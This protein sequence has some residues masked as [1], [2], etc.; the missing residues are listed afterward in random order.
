MSTNV[1]WRPGDSN[2]PYDPLSMGENEIA[3]M[4]QSFERDSND[5]LMV[6]HM[7]NIVHDSAA[8]EEYIDYLEGEMD[9]ADKRGE[10]L[11]E[12]MKREK[13]EWAAI[14]AFSLKLKNR[15]SGSMKA[16]HSC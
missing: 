13:T 5:P 14:D 2:N 1:K 4:I 11:Y 16:G 12:R 7:H 15:V 8:R 6:Q 10:T 3:D 9:A